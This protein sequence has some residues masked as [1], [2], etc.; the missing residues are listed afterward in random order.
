MIHIEGSG[1]VVAMNSLRD[2]RFLSFG[3]RE[4]DLAAA[5]AAVI[6]VAR[7]LLGWFQARSR[8]PGT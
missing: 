7:D 4:V 2:R 3:D 6:K 1:S 5:H 8:F